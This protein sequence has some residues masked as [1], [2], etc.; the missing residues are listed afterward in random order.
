MIEIWDWLIW[1][2]WQ[3]WRYKWK[4]RRDTLAESRAELY[5]QWENTLSAFKDEPA[6]RELHDAIEG[7]EE[8]KKVFG[9]RK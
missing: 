9:D 2:L 7:M 8:V 5:R 6:G 4:H 1:N 3:K